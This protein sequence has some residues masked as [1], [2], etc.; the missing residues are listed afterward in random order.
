MIKAIIVAL[1][2]LAGALGGT[3]GGILVSYKTATNWSTYA[4]Q[5]R[6]IADYPEITGG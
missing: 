6:A 5:F 4:V 3:F 2:S 1:L